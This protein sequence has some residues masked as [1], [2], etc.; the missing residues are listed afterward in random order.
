MVLVGL[1]TL[2]ASQWKLS[3]KKLGYSAV[4]QGDLNIYCAWL[5]ELMLQAVLCQSG[6][7]LFFLTFIVLTSCMQHWHQSGAVKLVVKLC[8]DQI[9]GYTQTLY[10]TARIGAGSKPNHESTASRT[11]P[12]TMPTDMTKSTSDEIRSRNALMINLNPVKITPMPI[13]S[14]IRGSRS[15]I[16][17][18]ME[19]MA[20][21]VT[22]PHNCDEYKENMSLEI[23]H[24]SGRESS[25]NTASVRAMKTRTKNRGVGLRS[26]LWNSLDPS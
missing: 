4:D 24:V 5:N 9:P 22:V 26:L 10:T 15:T 11:P 8:C 20:L 13:T 2:P 14:I 7:H 17:P 21:T 1:R 16:C 19:Y 25:A 23:L 6:F 18:R 3:D 12:T